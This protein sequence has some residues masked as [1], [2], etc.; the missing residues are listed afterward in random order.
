M[1]LSQMKMDFLT[2]VSHDLKNP[3]SLILAPVSQ[4][5]LKTKNPDNKKLLDGVHRNAMKINNLIQEVMTFEK[6]D[7]RS[8]VSELITS[9]LDLTAFVVRCFNE[10]K[11]I[12][13]YKHIEW[14]LLSATEDFLIQTDAAKLES[15]LN[16]LLDN[17]CKYSKPEGAV[18]ELYL[19]HVEKGVVIMIRDNGIG[20][21]KKDLPF[22]FSKFYRATTKEA[23]A[24]DGTGIGLYLVR[25]YAEQLGWTVELDSQW[26]EGTTV[27]INI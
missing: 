6:T 27:T 13:A 12:E 3:L 7:D 26:M 25:N 21:K 18:I 22:V 9:Q 16:N 2:A 19:K 10:W 1:E 24:I 20:I 11:R 4:L 23:Q 5:M 15:M 17:A 14:R 8:D